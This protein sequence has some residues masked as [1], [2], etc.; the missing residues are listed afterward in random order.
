[1]LMNHDLLSILV[2]IPRIEKIL[3]LLHKPIL[4]PLRPILLEIPAKELL[5]LRQFLRNLHILRVLLIL[6][7][8]SKFVRVDRSKGA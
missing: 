1:M 4:I 7:P 3:N 5:I 6:P 8:Q 2:H